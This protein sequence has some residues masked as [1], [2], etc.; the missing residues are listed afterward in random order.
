MKQQGMRGQLF[1]R[2]SA[3]QYMEQMQDLYNMD[4]SGDYEEDYGVGASE[5]GNP[6]G[7]LDNVMGHVNRGIEVVKKQSTD[8]YGKA[9]K[10]LAKT[11]Q[12]YAAPKKTVVQ[13]MQKNII[14]RSTYPFKCPPPLKV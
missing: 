4:Y 12:K 7:V 9:S 3:E 6:L 14:F 2:N 10:W 11:Y 13:F 8:L 5:G 1:D